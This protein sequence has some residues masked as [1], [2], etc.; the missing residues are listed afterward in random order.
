MSFSPV[1]PF[2]GLLGW[3]HLKRTGA[4]QMAAFAESGDMQRDA[5]HFRDRIASARTAEALVGDR[6]LLKVALGAFGLSADI[7]NR[8]FIRKVLEDGTL[9]PDALANK[10]ADKRYLQL[11]KA[12]GYGDYA[13]PRTQLSDFADQLL[14][15]YRIQAF[16]TAVG[17]QS[18]ALRLAMTAERELPGIAA[19]SR[20]EAGAWY[21]ILSS[22]PLREVFQT[23][24]GFPQSFGALDLDQQVAAFRDAAR[25]YIG[26]DAPRDFADGAAR[27]RLIRLFLLRGEA[28]A[29][30]AA[31]GQ[32]AALALL[33]GGARGGLSLRL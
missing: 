32:S 10:L 28:A 1:L 17:A 7:D 24:F 16:E 18:D 13:T 22:R 15:R 26:T 25:R 27:E 12:F 29:P 30:S 11:S 33:Q 21:A 19:E 8:F 14:G 9:S 20:S 3:S 2:S 5:A 4:R 31:S 6:R 23:A